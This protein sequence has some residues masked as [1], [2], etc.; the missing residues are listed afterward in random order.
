MRLPFFQRKAAAPPVLA[1][2]PMATLGWAQGGS[3]VRGYE[4]LVRDGFGRNP[5]GQRA[6]KTV[7][8]GVASAPF[9]VSPAGHPLA[10]VI[11]RPAPALSG[12][13]FFEGVASYLLLHGN[14]YI[15]TVDGADGAPVAMY[16]LRP[17][18]VTI[19]ADARG[20][21][22]AYVYRTGGVTT[23]YAA[24]DAEGR[25]GLLH[26]RTFNPLDDHYGLGCLGAAAAAIDTH[27]AA[28]VWNAALLQNSARPS[29]ALMY[30]PADGGTLSAEQYERL[31]AEMEAGFAGAANGGRPMLLEGGLR[32]QPMSM[33]PAELD[34]AASKA[35]AAREIA[36]AFGVPPM[37]LGLPG[38]NT[39]ANYAEANR[40]LWRL[41]LLPLAE[42][43]ADA[44][45]GYF[46]HW[47]PGIAVTID[48]DGI[49][50]LA[51]DRAALWAQVSAATFLTDTEKREMVG[52][53]SGE[54][55]A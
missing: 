42:K 18:R 27:N 29:G 49:P 52:M 10:A 16:A 12:T 6:V 38:D 51:Q 31:K 21:P 11:A 2:Y 41:T 33:T 43:L 32:W 3:A 45:S 8:E 39:Y 35:G 30:E 37:I 44:L 48:R 55:T 13:E 25:P 20:W 9:V 4:G 22:S 15:E 54:V 40:A 1:R 53:R 34:F 24:I 23:R 26:I 28:G 36:L 47:W 50:S 7:S 46:Q 5:I 19:E 17:E 14:A